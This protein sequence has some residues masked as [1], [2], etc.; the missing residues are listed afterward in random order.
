MKKIPPLLL[1]LVLLACGGSTD[2]ESIPGVYRLVS[3][4]GETLPLQAN[5]TLFRGEI[6][7]ASITLNTDAS[8][9]FRVAIRVT[10][11][12]Q[13]ASDVSTRNCTWDFLDGVLSLTFPGGT[14]VTETMDLSGDRIE[15]EDNG[16]VA[17]F[18]KQ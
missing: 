4:E 2:P 10:A 15:W 14:D 8:C 6:T 17:V 5:F 16:E 1:A 11:G 18:V 7:S 13:S 9:S 12:G 3:V